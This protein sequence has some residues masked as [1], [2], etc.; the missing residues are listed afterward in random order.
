MIE[1]L[2]GGGE[3]RQAPFARESLTLTLDEA[4][5]DEACQLWIYFYPM[6]SVAS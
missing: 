3:I 6:P 2:N 4:Q 1:S 5:P